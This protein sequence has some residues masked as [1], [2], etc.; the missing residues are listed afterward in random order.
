MPVVFYVKGS[1]LEIYGSIQDKCTKK[2]KK[3]HL[4]IILPSRV[5][6]INDVGTCD[7]N[8]SAC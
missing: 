6:E 2:K 8:L 5:R 1:M 4:E 7:A 3:K